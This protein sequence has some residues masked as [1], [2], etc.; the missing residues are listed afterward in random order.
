M[1]PHYGLLTFAVALAFAG[2]SLLA[3]AQSSPPVKKTPE[4]RQEA[5]AAF[6]ANFEAAD[7]NGDGGLSRE[8]LEHAKDLRNISRNFD[9]I[10]ADKDGKVT[11]REIQAWRR[12]RAQARKNKS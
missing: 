5:R 9:A 3:L 7:A 12:A 11:L 2:S 6:E 10:D 4:Q 1:K 8:E